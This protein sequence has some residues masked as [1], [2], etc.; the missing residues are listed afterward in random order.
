MALKC[1]DVL[2]IVIEYLS[3]K[4]ASNFSGVN[5]LF[6]NIYKRHGFRD[7]L[8][9]RS[10]RKMYQI[11]TH[12]RTLL[13]LTITKVNYID[14]WIGTY[15][16]DLVCLG[17]SVD[18]AL[19][20]FDEIQ[21]TICL[22]LFDFSGPIKWECFPYLETLITRGD[23]DLKGISSC[24]NL[25]K[26]VME[27]DGGFISVPDELLLK[28]VLLQTVIIKGIRTGRSPFILPYVKD[29][30]IYTGPYPYT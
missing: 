13:F 21:S 3:Q 19:P 11:T 2:T 23:I 28:C 30:S 29:F 12:T 14:R 22:T 17:C 4:D 26:I 10:D 18:V 15:P 5:K 20:M 7:F 24:K 6:N 27:Y 25:K 9:V 8:S 16:K 1:R